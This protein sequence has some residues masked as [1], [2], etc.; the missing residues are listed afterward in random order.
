MFHILH[1]LDVVHVCHSDADG[2]TP[3]DLEKLKFNIKEVLT[4][5]G[6][7]SFAMMHIKKIPVI[8]GK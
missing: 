6:L 5:S 1:G 3:A 4:M 7:Q 8:H 2:W